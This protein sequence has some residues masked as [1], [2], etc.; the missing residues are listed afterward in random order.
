MVAKLE[1]PPKTADAP[2]E[3]TPGDWSDRELYLMMTALVIPRPVGWISA[4]STSGVRNVAPSSY[5][6]FTSADFPRDQFASV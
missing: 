2:I 6:N 3:V 4:L 5:S 1:L